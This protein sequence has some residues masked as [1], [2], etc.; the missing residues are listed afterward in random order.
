MIKSK[1]FCKVLAILMSASLLGS[2]GVVPG[3]G[4]D[5][6]I[7]EARAEGE[8]VVD[9]VING[10]FFKRRIMN[11]P[12]DAFVDALTADA[13][14][15]H[16]CAIEDMRAEESESIEVEGK[17]VLRHYVL[18]LTATTS[19]LISRE[20]P[21]AERI[22]Y[23]QIFQQNKMF[24]EMENKVKSAKNGEMVELNW[25]EIKDSGWEINSVHSRLTS[26]AEKTLFCGVVEL[27][28]NTVSNEK[29]PPG[30]SEGS[31]FVPVGSDS[32][33]D[34]DHWAFSSTKGRGDGPGDPP[35]PAP[36][37]LLKPMFQFHHPKG[38]TPRTPLLYPSILSPAWQRRSQSPVTDEVLKKTRVYRAY[39]TMLGIVS[40]TTPEGQ[41]RIGFLG[42]EPISTR[43]I[44]PLEILHALI[45]IAN[46]KP[47]SPEASNAFMR[48]I[49][50]FPLSPQL[51][52]S[53]GFVQKFGCA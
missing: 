4:P 43:S 37:M 5:A 27:Q 32:L 1:K 17:G 38:K 15:M 30:E 11:V 18:N 26:L 12:I 31:M 24:S 13:P 50:K 9:I 29:T 41:I 7:I 52:A 22:C 6:S 45:E 28:L 14:E 44:D 53:F 20:T 21:S 47:L 46:G 3:F 40:E 2:F 35:A 49:E 33:F 34:P 51:T 36:A 8:I 23:Y 10:I 16:D 25:S 42:G 39:L 48:Y 19:T